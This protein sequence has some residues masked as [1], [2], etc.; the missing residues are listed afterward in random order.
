MPPGNTQESDVIVIEAKGEYR[1]S[2]RRPTTEFRGALSTALL[3]LAG[4]VV[5]ILVL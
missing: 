1:D 5:L 4:F 2:R 3:A